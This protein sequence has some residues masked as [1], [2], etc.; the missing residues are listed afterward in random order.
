MSKLLSINNKLRSLRGRLT[1][2]DESD[3]VAYDAQGE[4]SLF[5]LTWRLAKSGKEIAT[6]RKK[7]FSW[8]PTWII[9]GELGAFIIRREIWSW[10][11]CYRIIGGPFDGAEVAGNIWDMKFTISHHDQLIAR[12]KGMILSLRD[13]HN[14]EVLQADPASESFTAIAMVTLQMDRRDEN[15][16]RND[17][18]K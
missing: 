5:S 4:F 13:R 6:I 16:N 15:S 11:R 10:V 18:F 2:T 12:A 1:I 9:N 17:S 3:E 8:S 14:I 7:A